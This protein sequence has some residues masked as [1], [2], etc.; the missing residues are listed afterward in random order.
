MTRASKRRAAPRR[1]P[2]GLALCVSAAV[3]A[4]AALTAATVA[5]TGTTASAAS[6][7]GVTAPGFAGFSMTSTT[8]APSVVAYDN[9]TGTNG[10]AI[11]NTTTD[12]GGFTW[13]VNAGTWTVQ[14]NKARDTSVSNGFL[15]FNSGL[16][17]GSVEAKI[18]RNGNNSWD[19]YVIFNADSTYG[20]GLLADWWSGN[21][22]S[23]E[24]YKQT[25]AGSFISV[26]GVTNLYPGTI[27]ASVTLRMES[28]SSSII[29]IYLDGVL[30]F[31]YTL[32]SGEQ[33]AYKNASHHYAGIGA[34]FDGTSS[35]DNFHLDA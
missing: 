23:I 8:G 15:I 32:T 27:P 19:T 29:K 11:K 24:L 7:G 18:S 6:L 28:P 25:S 33:T 35:F 9:F 20:T 30:Q 14:S 2:V 34:H 16:S 3:A 26:A 22:G 1:Y 13:T 31:S 21:S 4:V 10:T 12:D 5:A 17:N